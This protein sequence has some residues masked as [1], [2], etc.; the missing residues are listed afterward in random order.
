MY[1]LWE[2]YTDA[3]K[4]DPTSP[5]PPHPR[6]RAA[7][8]QSAEAWPGAQIRSLEA[9]AGNWTPPCSE[10]VALGK[11]LN[12]SVPQFPRVDKCNSYLLAMKT[13]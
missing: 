10:Y 12:R 1:L 6:V 7:W 4:P 3:I 11:R 13:K 2:T 8:K 5:A 9:W